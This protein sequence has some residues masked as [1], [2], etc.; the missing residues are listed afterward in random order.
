[1][2]EMLLF[3]CASTAKIAKTRKFT[4]GLILIKK[5]KQTKLD[6]K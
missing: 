1:M 4:V 5:E 3:T 6:E 2:K